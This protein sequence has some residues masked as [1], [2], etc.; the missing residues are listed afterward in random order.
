MKWKA[1]NKLDSKVAVNPAKYPGEHLHIDAS[2]PLPLP[3]ERK[4]YWLNIRDE[5][6]GYSWDYFMSEKSSTTEI[7]KRQLQWMKA[8][9]I[10]VKTVRCNNA[11]D[12]MVPLDN[13]CRANGVMVD[14]VAS[15]TPQ[16]NGKVKRQ[17]PTD[18]KGANDMFD[19]VKQSVAHK[20]KLQKE[21]IQYES[22]MA[23]ISIKDYKSPYEKFFGAPSPITPE[24]CV[25]FG[26]IGYVAD[27]NILKNKYR[28]H[29]VGYAMNPGRIHTKFF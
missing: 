13:M 12:Q 23:N 7:L 15:Y 10:R 25:N 28:C 26:R 24:T 22:T 5:F 1:Q 3:M 27:G 11:K 29:M 14:Y 18:L 2:G 20:M 21:G 17:F 19:T 9:G 16:Q 8:S 4:E 6:S